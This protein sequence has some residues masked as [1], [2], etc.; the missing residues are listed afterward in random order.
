MHGFGV[1]P[2]T[3]WL[4]FFFFLMI[5]RPPRSTRCPYT[6]LFR[7]TFKGAATNRGASSKAVDGVQWVVR[8]VKMRVFPTTRFTRSGDVILLQ[9][10]V[11]LF[12]VMSDSVKGVGQF[13]FDLYA[14]RGE[15]GSKTEKFL[16]NWTIN[17]RTLKEQALYY[18]PVM[19]GYHFPLELHKWPVDRKSKRLN[20]SHW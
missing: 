12:D 13:S 11:E 18:D 19:R 2:L 14:I 8:P 1:T 5:R 7:S 15:K 9:A 17:V 16:Y 3:I 20:S 4:M 6:T 10:R